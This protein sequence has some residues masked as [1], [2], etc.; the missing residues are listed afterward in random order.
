MRVHQENELAGIDATTLLRSASGPTGATIRMA[1]G[2]V[3]VVTRVVGPTPIADISG[4]SVRSI[5][6]LGASSA[7]PDAAS[8]GAA[9]SK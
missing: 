1:D 8:R 6:E 2:S 5:E 3:Y 4:A 9:H 7:M